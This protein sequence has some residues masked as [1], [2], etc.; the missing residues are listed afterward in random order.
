VVVGTPAV[1]RTRPET[2]PLIGLFMNMLV[3]RTE[4]NDDLSF[5]DLLLRVRDVCLGAYAHQDMPFER[6]VQ[7]LEPT[8]DMSRTP[9]FQVIFTLQS[10]S[11]EGMSLPGLTVRGLGGGS[12]TAKFELSLG[13]SDG[14]R[15]LFGSFE[16]NTDLF[17]AATIDRMVEHFHN[18][19][20]AAVR[21]PDK[22]LW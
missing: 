1:N 20:D 16:Y 22:K 7:E 3:L 5:Q 8:R 14:P 9:L 21:E 6:L 2:E 18:L 10:G 17:D 19:L 15:G 4:M 12:A 11:G 13:M